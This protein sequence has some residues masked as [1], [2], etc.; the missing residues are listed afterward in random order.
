MTDDDKMRHLLAEALWRIDTGGDSPPL[1]QASP[2]SHRTYARAATDL[3]PTVRAI[4]AAAYGQGR[5]DE[6]AGLP[7]AVRATT[8]AYGTGCTCG[9]AW[10]GHPNPHALTCPEYES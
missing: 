8:T 5:D 9:E 6:A 3:L 10:S 4:A 2:A 7:L 1:S